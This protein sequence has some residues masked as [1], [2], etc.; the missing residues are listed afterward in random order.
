MKAEN[1]IIGAVSIVSA[2][3]GDVV[4]QSIAKIEVNQIPGL[5]FGTHTHTKIN[6]LTPAHMCTCDNKT[7]LEKWFP[8]QGERAQSLKVVYNIRMSVFKNNIIE[9][10][11]RR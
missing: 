4:E 9:M 1:C 8:L 10:R 7:I 11:K 3:I 2:S 6:Q 5:L